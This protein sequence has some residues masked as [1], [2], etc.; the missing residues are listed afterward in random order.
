MGRKKKV[1]ADRVADIV[2]DK[3]YVVDTNIILDGVGSLM[4][5]A[6]EGTNRIILPEIVLDELDEKKVG[7]TDLAFRAR[8]FHR[9]FDPAVEVSSEEVVS[10]KVKTT[11]VRYKVKG[12]TIDVISKEHYETPDG[13][14]NSN[15]LKILEIA[16]MFPEAAVI[17]NDTAMRIRARTR[18]IE[19][20]PYRKNRVEQL[21]KINFIHEL[22]LPEDKKAKLLSGGLSTEE[23]SPGLKNL[24]NVVFTIQETGEKI[25]A[26]HK[27]SK[28]HPLDEKLLRSMPVV[29]KTT[30]QLFFLN[31]LIDPDTSIVVCA[32]VSGSGKNLLALQA[33]LYLQ[34]KQE[35]MP[36]NYCRNTVTAGDPAAQLGFLKGDE[37]A[38]LS[39]F[40]FPL[41]DSVDTYLAIEKAHFLKQ[42][43][44]IPVRDPRMFFDD[45]N[46]NVVNINQ[47]R[48]SNLR[49]FLI[50]DEWQNSSDAVNKLM[51][52]R[53][54]EGSKVVILGDVN[55]IDHPTL[56]KH[57][58]ALVTMLKH[59]SGNGQVAGCTLSRVQRGSIAAFAEQFL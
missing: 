31:Q 54:I 47:A 3:T 33:A 59:A 17:S 57:Q 35:D 45:H 41:V 43:K 34:K 16:A 28:F 46:L 50:F 55:Q 7:F 6:Q 49:G 26:Y 24:A 5:L 20:Q 12:I 23:V 18:K 25:L 14:K 36:I 19:A 27:L 51:I 52:S 13:K 53:I 32:G 11:L 22:F 48:G 9:F 21:D 4:E 38:K 56:N 8:E 40:S 30:E 29:P 15:D 42:K 44:G 10:H 58:N 37:N 2:Y 39:V 1:V